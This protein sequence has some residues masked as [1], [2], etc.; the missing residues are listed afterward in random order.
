MFVHRRFQAAIIGGARVSLLHHDV[1]VLSDQ[2]PMRSG[3]AGRGDMRPR[4]R[5]RD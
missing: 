1:S 3:P 5:L 2:I 4:G